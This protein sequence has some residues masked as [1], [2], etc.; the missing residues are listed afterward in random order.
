MVLTLRFFA[1]ALFDG[2]FVPA[3]KAPAIISVFMHLYRY[4]YKLKPFVF[5]N[6]YVSIIIS[7]PP[8]RLKY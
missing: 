1:K 8:W 2:S 5:S 6:E 4:S 3:H 7:M